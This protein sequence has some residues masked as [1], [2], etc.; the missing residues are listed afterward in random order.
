M[1]FSLNGGST[2]EADT[3]R[4]KEIFKGYIT[5]FQLNACNTHTHIAIEVTYAKS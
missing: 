5:L 3:T 4:N 1:I 2:S